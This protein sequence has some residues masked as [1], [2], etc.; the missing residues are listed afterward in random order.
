MGS[1]QADYGDDFVSH[2]QYIIYNYESAVNLMISAKIILFK[3]KLIFLDTCSNSKHSYSHT[4]PL[5]YVSFTLC[6]YASLA[7]FS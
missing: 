2:F 5:Y 3:S 7:T 1:E 6:I 4:K